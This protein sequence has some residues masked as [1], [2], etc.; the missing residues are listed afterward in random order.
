MDFQVTP[1]QRVL[2]RAVREFAEGRVAPIA[3]ELDQ[4]A[5]FP[6]ELV[7]AMKAM[8]LFGLQASPR[9]GGAGLDTI[10]YAITIEELARVCAALALTVTVHNSVALYPIEAYGTEEQKERLLPGM[11]VGDRIGAFC[12]TE[13][14]AGSD[15]SSIIEGYGADRAVLLADP[16]FAGADRRRVESYEKR[17]QNYSYQTLTPG[18]EQK[19]LRAFR[20]TI[21]PRRDHQMIEYKHEG[22]E[23]VYV[24]RGEVEIK[25]GE[26]IHRLRRRESLHFEASIPHHLRNPSPQTAELIVVLYTP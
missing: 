23:F 14:N 16:A 6:W 24:L 11:C 1:K 4:Q 13:P 12:L 20:V 8:N 2:R 3:H 25:V 7:D 22:E 18:A 10:S 5:R 21:D 26:E 15:V 17:T 9:W 19:H